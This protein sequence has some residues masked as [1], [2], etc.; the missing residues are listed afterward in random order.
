MNYKKF[1]FTFV[2]PVKCFDEFISRDVVIARSLE[3]AQDIIAVNYGHAEIAE[4]TQT[5]FEMAVQFTAMPSKSE[6]D[7]TDSLLASS[8]DTPL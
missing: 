3:V 2:N 8:E 4:V 6:D 1:T 5:P 7:N